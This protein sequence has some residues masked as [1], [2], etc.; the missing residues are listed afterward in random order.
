MPCSFFDEEIVRLFTRELEVLFHAVNFLQILAYGYVGWSF[1]MALI[2]VFDG[3]GDT[4]TA[5]FINVLCVWIIQVPLAYCPALTLGW[6]PAWIFWSVF[7]ADN[8]TCVLGV[9][10]FRRGRWRALVV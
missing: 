10:A 4:I 6:G 5:T 2:Q 3:A 8:L 1:G 7:V 9:F